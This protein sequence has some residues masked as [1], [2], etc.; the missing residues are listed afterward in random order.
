MATHAYLRVSTAEQDLEKNKAEILKFVNDRKLGNVEFWEEK[1]SG[2]VDFKERLIADILDKLGRND[3]IIVNELSRL[4]RSTLQ[5]LQILDIARTKG[6]N[7]YAIK[8]GWQLD[9]TI[10]SKIVSTMFAM[11]SEIERDLISERTKEAL[12]AKK[13]QGIKLGRPKGPGKSKLDIYKD[14]IVAFLKTGYPK[15]KIAKK[16]GVSRQNVYN[17]IQKNNIDVKEEL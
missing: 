1:I 3:N 13:A 16:Y 8:G 6:I 10:Q 5:I 9:D 7:V 17:W 2:R 14:E 12:R 4:G 15:T 11:L